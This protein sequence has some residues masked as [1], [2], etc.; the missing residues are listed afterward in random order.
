MSRI[1]F[2]RV[3]S[4]QSDIYDDDG[5]CV[6]EVYRQPDVL[7]PGSHYYVVHLVEDYRGPVRVTADRVAIS[8]ATHTRRRQTRNART[9]FRL[10]R[11]T[12][13]RL[14]IAPP[15]AGR[16]SFEP[17]PRAHQAWRPQRTGCAA[18]LSICPA[19]FAGSGAGCAWS[20]TS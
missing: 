19:P 11:E 1:T 13:R 9:A 10:P 6:G 3:A 14:V 8:T 12:S 16:A 5:D 17:M 4:E 15:R 20:I 2:K 7:N 18:T